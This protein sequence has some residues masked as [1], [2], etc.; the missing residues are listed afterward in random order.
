[1]VSSFVSFMSMSGYSM[2]IWC[3]F[4]L[5]ALVLIGLYIQSLRFLRMSEAELKLLQ[6]EANRNET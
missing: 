6:Q 1:M 3:S 2:F 5:S 4:G